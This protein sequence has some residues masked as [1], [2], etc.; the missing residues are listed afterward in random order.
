VF[1]LSV[2][3]VKETGS[4]RATKFGT[5][6]NLLNRAGFVRGMCY[7]YSLYRF[8]LIPMTA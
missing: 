4:I 2:L 6:T 5:R 7:S 8:Y 1:D 3:D